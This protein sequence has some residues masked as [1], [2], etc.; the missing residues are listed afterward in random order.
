M[1]LRHPVLCLWSLQLHSLFACVQSFLACL[2]LSAHDIHYSRL[3]HCSHSLF[4]HYYFSCSLQLPS[5]FAFCTVIPGVSLSLCSWHLLLSFDL[6][7]SFNLL[8]VLSLCA[9]NLVVA[10][11]SY[12]LSLLTTVI[13]GVPLSNFRSTCGHW[14]QK[15]EVSMDSS[16]KQHTATCVARLIGPATHLNMLQ[17]TSICCNTLQYAATY[18]NMLQHTSMCC[19]SFLRI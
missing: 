18:F 5:L 11:Y 12:T 1:H 16:T 19:N 17:H 8:Q 13:L 4:V 14:R 15:G 6:L 2:S 3:T 7:L 10:H 9:L